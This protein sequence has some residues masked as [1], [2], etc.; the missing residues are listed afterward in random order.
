MEKKTKRGRFLP[1]GMTASF[2]ARVLEAC[3]EDD[4][5]VVKTEL[6]HKAG[7]READQRRTRGR[8]SPE[9]DICPEKP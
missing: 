9:T 5:D 6:L 4:V 2:P 1:P 3:H 8:T 7:R